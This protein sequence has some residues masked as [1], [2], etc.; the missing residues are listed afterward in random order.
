MWWHDGYWWGVLYS[1][2]DNAYNIHRLDASSQDWIDTGVLV[3]DRVGDPDSETDS[4]RRQARADA[5]MDSAADKLYI[6]SHRVHDQ[7]RRNDTEVNQAR[8]MVYSYDSNTG[9][10]TLDDGFPVSVNRDMT[11]SVVLDK[12]D[13]G[14]LWVSYVSQDTD[15]NF[16]V[17]VNASAPDDAASWGTPLSCPSAM[18]RWST[19]MISLRCLRSGTLAAQGRRH[20]VKPAYARPRQVLYCRTRRGRG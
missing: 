4:G 1:A 19:Q 2:G 6:V 17:Y 16:Y 12:D 13:A 20:V 3:D 11:E 14:R 15:N 5:L 7:G 8:L 18:R 9:T 10:W